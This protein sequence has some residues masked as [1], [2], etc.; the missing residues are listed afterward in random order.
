MALEAAGLLGFDPVLTRDDAPPKP[1]PAGILRACE[2]WQIETHQLLMVGDFVF[3][4]EAGR[5]AGC[6]TLLISHGRSLPF[7][8]KADAVIRDHSEWAVD[9]VKMG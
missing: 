4:L 1:D 3:D 6:R 8:D 7:A 2:L 5:A 9:V